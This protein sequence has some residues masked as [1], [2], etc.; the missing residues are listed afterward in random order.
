VIIDGTDPVPALSPDPSTA[1]VLGVAISGTPS[2]DEIGRLVRATGA[3]LI[4]VPGDH[5][6]DQ[7]TVDNAV[8]AGDGIAVC[9]VITQFGGDPWSSAGDDLVARCARLAAGGVCAVYLHTP[10]RPDAEPDG[11]RGDALF[12]QALLWADR[13]RTESGVP[14]L[15]DG[16]DGWARSVHRQTTADW[17]ARLHVAIISGRVDVVVAWPLTVPSPSDP[18]RSAC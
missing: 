13:I 12:E 9:A 2:A 5:D 4:A 3:R 17:A 16:P 11:E 6:A 1:P 7:S 18:R 15:I 8:K 14:V 10:D